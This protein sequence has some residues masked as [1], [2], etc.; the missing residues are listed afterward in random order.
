MMERMRSIRTRV[1]T[2]TIVAILLSVM[3]V[4]A[5]AIVS[6]RREADRHAAEVLKLTC[7]S[8]CD[9]INRF[10][11]YAE[12]GVNTVSRLAHESLDPSELLDAGVIGATG[13]G[14]SLRGHEPSESQ[15]ERLNAYLKEYLA[16]TQSVFDVVAESN[17]NVLTYYVRINPELGGESC[18]YWYAKQ[19]T[20]DFEPRRLTSIN[21]Y[22]TDDVSHV[23]WYYLPLESGKPTWLDPYYNENMDRTIISYVTPIY[24]C[25]TFIGVVG[26]DL[27]FEELTKQI[28]SIEI[29]ETGYAF[30][31]DNKGKIVYHPKLASGQFLADI[32]N[33]LKAAG[34]S[35]QSAGPISYRFDG[36]AKKA[37]WGTLSNGL[38]LIVSVPLREIN[39]GWYG[40]SFYIGVT[41]ALALVLFTMVAASLMRHITL[42]LEQLA[43]AAKQLAA[44]NYDVNLTYDGNDEVGVLTKSF[45]Q[46]EHELHSF[47][48]DLNSKAYRDDL[49]GVKNK[50]ALSVYTR[51]LD[52]S[53]KNPDKHPS[54]ALTVFDCNNL[55]LINDNFGHERGDQYLQAACRLICKVYAH[56]P[57]FRTGGDEFVVILTLEDLRNVEALEAR[58]D[59]RAQEEN[60]LTT[61][62]WRTVDLARGRASFDPQVDPDVASVLHRADMAMYEDKRLKKSGRSSKPF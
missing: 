45:L 13:S 26:V 3:L 42:P 20:V 34:D 15:R 53:I 35:Q 14:R 44:G 40:M 52:D 55:K 46:M 25:G 56:S 19:R 41:A 62:P 10:L 27:D 9:E 54:F 28:E 38:T 22:A 47:I 61:D 48:S 49:T 12:E 16:D 23:G 60:A 50:A 29:L 6:A 43:D 1:T 57:V 36:M 33:E 21:G 8:K 30:L 4:G 37:V 11:S 39:Q 7:T 59:A 5:I 32:N 51:R 24:R 2:L 18:G 17:P 58:F 31:T